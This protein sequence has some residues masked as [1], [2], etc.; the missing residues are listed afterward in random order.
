MRLHLPWKDRGRNNG[1]EAQPEA[2]RD[3]AEANAA[4]RKAEQNYEEAKSQQGE[5]SKVVRL[6]KERQ[7]V[8]HF[9]DAVVRSLQE[10]YGPQNQGHNHG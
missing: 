5:V 6:L 3:I 8:N 9:R 1:S 10:G 7:R 4:V 2:H